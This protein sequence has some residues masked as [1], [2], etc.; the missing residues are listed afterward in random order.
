MA[1]DSEYALGATI[2]S[3][4]VRT[5][6]WTAKKLNAGIVWM[7]TNEGSKI[8]APYGGNK[9]SGIGREDGIIGLMEYLRAKNN[10]LYVG[11][12]YEDFYNFGS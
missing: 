2:W 10:V 3:E 8:E 7:N 4:N 12:D 5:L 11:K 9:N 6:Y 1:N